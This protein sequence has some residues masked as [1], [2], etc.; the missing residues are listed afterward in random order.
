[1]SLARSVPA[2]VLAGA[3]SLAPPGPLA[4]QEM[5]FQGRIE[6]ANRATL[7]TGRDGKVVE[8][9]FGGGEAVE[10]GDPLIR[11]DDAFQALDLEIAAAEARAAR[12][13]AELARAEA[14]RMEELGRRDVAS[15]AR[16]DAA[17]AQAEVAAAD[18]ERAAAQERAA[19]LRLERSVLRAP[20]AGR[21]GAPAVA[22]GDFVEAAV[23]PPLAE[24]VQL[25]P[26]IVAYQVPYDD[27]LAALRRAGASDLATLFSRLA[28]EV[29]TAGGALSAG[30]LR[31]EHA[32]ATVD[33]ATGMLTVRARLP[34]PDELFRPG[35]RVEVVSTLAPEA[36]R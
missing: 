25:D 24:I 27:R 5:L 31:P 19:R 13:R 2:L 30:P 18:A 3:V 22:V 23:G 1:M 7:T 26:L 36:A 9:L 12:A 32:D 17:R 29:R 20:L 6:A 33:P 34:N 35:M 14:A 8:V 4:A 10:K 16:L 15:A 11:L 28:L 21:I